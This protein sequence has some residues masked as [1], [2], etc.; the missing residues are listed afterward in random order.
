MDALL[1]M[2]YPGDTFLITEQSK[3]IGLNPKVYLLGVGVANP[4]YRDKFGTATVE[5]IMGFGVTNPKLPYPGTKEYFE[6]HTKRFNKQPDRWASAFTYAS[7][8]VL[9]QAI[10]KSGTLDRKKLRDVIASDTFM[11]VAGP[12]KFVGGFNIHF[13]GHIG[14]WHNGE[15]EVVAPKKNRAIEPIFPKPDWR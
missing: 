6:R 13:P 15:F 1:G 14:Q 9:E 4:F 10:E 12:V 5:G 11:T 8:Q 7:L 3:V 2:S